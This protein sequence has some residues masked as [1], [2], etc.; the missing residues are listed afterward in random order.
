MM[1]MV[2][3]GVGGGGGDT[4]SYKNQC[5][6]APIDINDS[7]QLPPID[8]NDSRQLIILSAVKFYTISSWLHHIVKLY[9][10]FYRTSVCACRPYGTVRS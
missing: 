6:L 2:M 5:P 4:D 7:R 3:G 9:A 10:L 1:Y 8:I